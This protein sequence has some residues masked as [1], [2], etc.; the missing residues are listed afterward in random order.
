MNDATRLQLDEARFVHQ[1]VDGEVLI[2]D[3]QGGA[4]FCLRGGAALLWPLLV[5]GAARATLLAAA[6]AAFDGPAGDIGASVSEFIDRLT[7]ESILRPVTRAAANGTAVPMAAPTAP[8]MAPLT[9]IP[10]APLT[11]ERYDDMRDLLTLDPVHDVADSG[12]PNLP[13]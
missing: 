9:K 8:P 3:V 5:G 4:Y 7:A 13:R 2:I 10:F 1:T 12:W 11:I 6:E